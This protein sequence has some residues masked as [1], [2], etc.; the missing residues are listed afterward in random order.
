M[1]AFKLPK[2]F[3]DMSE[4][5]FESILPHIKGVFVSEEYNENLMIL[6]HLE[7]ELENLA[8]QNKGE[9][10]KQT[11]INLSADAWEEVQKYEYDICGEKIQKEKTNE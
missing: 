1:K 5:D 7:Q 3:I 6:W 11:F 4:E 8:A 9:V 2:K 10:S